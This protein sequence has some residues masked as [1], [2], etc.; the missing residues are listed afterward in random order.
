[1][2]AVLVSLPVYPIPEQRC[3][4][5]FSGLDPA[6]NQIT[7]YPVSA[8]IG[9]RVRGD[10]DA[11]KGTRVEEY[12]GKSSLPWVF[13]PDVGG[14]YVFNVEE[15]TINAPRGKRFDLDT[16]GSP[17][18]AI[19]QTSTVS[20]FVGERMTLSLGESPHA[21]QLACYVWNETI[22]ATTLAVHGED[23]PALSG[24][25]SPRSAI[26]ILDAALLADVATMSGSTVA[27]FTGTFADQFVICRDAY[28]L[29]LTDATFGGQHENPDD[30]NLCGE[31][32]RATDQTLA[33]TALSEFR[34][35]LSAHAVT[36]TDSGGLGVHWEYPDSASDAF[37]LSGSSGS[38]SEQYLALADI[39]VRLENHLA[40][41]GPGGV[42][43]HVGV[44]NPGTVLGICPMLTLCRDY[45]RALGSEIVS[46][47]DGRNAGAA[48][49]EQLAGFEKS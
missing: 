30:L 23:T 13:T 12:T 44:D 19:A 49:L 27:A 7:I 17:D 25:T 40:A 47:P 16:Y 20:L 5:T 11:S 38:R 4:L 45:L 33:Q 26:A 42:D 35:R 15:S 28:D 24:A 10:I 21:A 8:P 2:S 14:R 32:L 29:H 6:T 36:M 34:R 41:F 37:I 43:W 48:K 31:G 3:E 22:R 1:M 39:I 9:S 18:P 46:I